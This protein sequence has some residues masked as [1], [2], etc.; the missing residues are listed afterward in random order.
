M[1]KIIMLVSSAI[2]CFLIYS[3]HKDSKVIPADYYFSANKNG[4]GWG[5]QGNTYSI[6]GDSLRLAAFRPTGEEH[7]NISIKFDGNGIYL[8]TGNQ[9]EFF[10][11]IGLDVLTS[12][13]R[14]DT[15]R[16]NSLTILSYS[17]KTGII[18]GRFELHVLKDG[19][20]NEYVPIDFN[21]GMFRVKLPD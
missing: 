2:C 11:T 21:N 1:K 19:D 8:L 10:T 13:Y 20:P 15:T 16:N 5:A 17:T 14:L 12:H 4:T 3:C 7:I 18:S 6:P 9:A